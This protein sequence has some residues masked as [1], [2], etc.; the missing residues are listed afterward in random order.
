ML[1]SL[2]LLFI[3]D[4]RREL[5]RLFVNN[6]KE[7]DR[8]ATSPDCVEL[9][10]FYMKDKQFKQ[11]RMYVNEIW[12]LYQNRRKHLFTG[13]EVENLFR[14]NQK[15]NWMYDDF[16]K[17]ISHTGCFFQRFGCYW[18]IFLIWVPYLSGSIRF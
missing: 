18:Y 6:T 2:L 13:A 16:S 4:S 9:W 8:P 15:W 10:G 5:Y 1:G 11:I 3:S 12:S 17:F 7:S 14:I